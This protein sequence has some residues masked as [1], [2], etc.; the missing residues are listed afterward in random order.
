MHYFFI[1]SIILFSGSIPFAFADEYIVDIPFGAYNPELNTPAEVWYDPPLINVIVGDTITWYND[2]RETHTVTSGDGPGRFGWMDNKN[3]GKPDGI[4]DSGEFSPGDSWSY[5]FEESGT[6]SYFCTIHP[7]MEGIVVVEK[8]IP[9]YPHD[10]TGQKVEFPLLQ[11]TPDLDLEVNLSWD[12]PVIKTHEKI[13]FVYQF[14]D[15]QTNSNLA[16]M[17]YDFVIFQNGQ[18][19]FRDEGLSQIGGDYRNFVFTDSGSIIVRI[20]GIH[21]PSLLAEESVTVFGGVESKEQRSVDFTA[22][23]Y[24]NP[25]KTT[26]ETFHIKP[27][28]RLTTYYELMIVIILIPAVMFIAVLFWLK[29]KPDVSKT[30]PGAVKV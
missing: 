5:K 29:K 26:H 21:S 25:E 18:E 24:D 22:A 23:V 3:F 20:E 8:E 16:E 17:K 1:L 9:D 27:A 6:F 30:K 11:Y 14:Y 12:P 4:F 10:A 15:P 7:W 19:I 13:Q 2:D 28:Q